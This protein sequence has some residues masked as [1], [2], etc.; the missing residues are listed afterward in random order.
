MFYFI[1]SV[2]QRCLLTLLFG[3]MQ[4]KSPFP[5]LR[6]SASSASPATSVHNYNFQVSAMKSFAMSSFGTWASLFLVLLVNMANLSTYGGSVQAAV[7]SRDGILPPVNVPLDLLPKY[8][9]LMDKCNAGGPNTVRGVNPTYRR[10]FSHLKHY[11]IIAVLYEGGV[12]ITYDSGECAARKL[13]D[14]SP[15]QLSVF[16]KTALCNY[17][18]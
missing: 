11:Q 5:M 6:N 8:F 10:S 4:H 13:K 7:L 17:Y 16:C 2:S 18:P 12:E 14:G 15:F 1:L 9:K 3:I